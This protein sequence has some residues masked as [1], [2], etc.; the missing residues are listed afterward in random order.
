MKSDQIN[1][2]IF[3]GIGGIGMS[4]L[5]RYY[6][7]RGCRVYGYDKTPS[8]LTEQL[9]KEGIDVF[10]KDDSHF[11]SHDTDLA[12]YT[13]AIPAGNNVLNAVKSLNIPLYKRAAILGQLSKEHKCIAVA[14]TH[15]KTSI[16]GLLAHIFKS[17]DIP[18][19]AFMG[20]ISNNYNTNIL[21]HEKPKYMIV[22]ADEYD[23]SFHHLHS[24]ITLVSAI[25]P[26]HL[27]IYGDFKNLVEAFNAFIGLTA[28]NGTVI[29]H[30]NLLNMCC[31]DISYGLHSGSSY[32]ANDVSVSDNCYHY[33]ITT[34][35]NRVKITSKIPGRHNVEN[36]VAAMAAAVEAGLSV[37][38]VKKGIESYKGMHRRFEVVI[39]D[40]KHV[41]ID[42]YAHHP[43]ELEVCIHTLKELYPDKKITGVF[44]PHLYSRTADHAIKFAEALSKLDECILL[45]IYPAREEPLPGVTS[46][47]IKDKIS[48]TIVSIIE[49]EKLTEYIK[50]KNPEVL[51]TMGAGDIDRLVPKI[52]K[53]LTAIES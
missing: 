47:I 19:L 5:A 23:R 35:D 6:K 50:E 25:A 32:F 46:E 53:V 15:G 3:I 16:T 33:H 20:G 41:F 37:Q 42:D 29:V 49:Y 10:F 12:I 40:E 39:Q 26:D 30:Q 45:D 28:P 21:Y 18:V 36:S 31:T 8:E 14:G 9:Q 22:E 1:T 44:Q 27:D 38:Q 43:E 11:V 24:D 52:K 2:V 7:Y 48:D 13:P 17:A 4:A 34:P 51:V